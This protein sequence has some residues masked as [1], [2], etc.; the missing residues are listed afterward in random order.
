MQKFD[1]IK[2]WKIWLCSFLV[3]SLFALATFKTTQGLQE[4]TGVEPFSEVIKGFLKTYSWYSPWIL[5]TPF[6]YVYAPRVNYRQLGPTRFVLAQIAMSAV[7]VG[8]AALV[9]ITLLFNFF[10]TKWLQD[11]LYA[12]ISHY[13]V[14]K[15]WYFDL[16][17][18]F[19]ILAIAF[20]RHFYVVALTETQ[21]ITELEAQLVN[22]ELNALKSQLN[23][24]F[25]FNTLNSVSGLIRLDKKADANNALS[26]LSSMLRAVLENQRKKLIPLHREM[27]FIGSYLSIQ[28]L[29]FGEKLDI[30]VEVEEQA[31]QELVPFMILQ[32]L[33]EN[34]V[35]HGSQM[36]SDKNTL[37]LQVKKNVDSV[38]ITLVNK[39]PENG[40]KN[41][42]GIGLENCRQRLS[43]IYP[44]NF[45]LTLNSLPNRYFETFLKIP[46]GVVL[47]D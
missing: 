24:H 5:F 3:F 33:V 12:S 8:G 14:N 43:R 41:G 10:E 6:V 30:E 16:P 44:N 27:D 7:F 4:S 11:T 18:Y 40:E 22:T 15:Y 21:R 26:E 47:D 2:N 1:S 25:L 17:F 37:R 45:E 35:Q 19:S 28:K 38:E 46:T 34:A 39:V 13:F 36:E 9:G 23:P 42:F 20:T 29:R 31:K 32:P